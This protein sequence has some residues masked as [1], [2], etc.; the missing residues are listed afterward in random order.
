M[1]TFN[2]L[3]KSS[4]THRF[5][6]NDP[7]REAA[8]SAVC[9]ISFLVSFCVLQVVCR[10]TIGDFVEWMLCTS[11]HQ[12]SDGCLYAG[13]IDEQERNRRGTGEEQERNRRPTRTASE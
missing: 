1:L 10:K 4:G 9:S 7:V 6:P 5:A 13:L 11:K 3:S 2:T 12:R 8:G